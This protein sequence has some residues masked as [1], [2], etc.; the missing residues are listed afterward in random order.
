ML[1]KL[2]S[3]KTR[4]KLLI[5]FFLNLAKSSHLRR[6]AS[7]FNESTNSIRLEL[8]NLSGAGYLI[9]KKV[10]NKVKYLA[11]SKHPLFNIIIKLVKKHTG[12]E[13]II[14]NI[15]D[16]IYNIKAIYLVGDYAKGVDS[17]TINIYIKAKIKDKKY[18]NEIL[19]KT[20]KKIKRKIVLIDKIDPF[21][22]KLLIYE[23]K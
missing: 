3:S 22:E 21:E 17:G 16:S 19:E 6:L 11:N 9:K 8:N 18:I 2:I 4:L 13:N 7:D 10:G 20:E 1:E 12:V 14:S 5:R 15:L 23:A